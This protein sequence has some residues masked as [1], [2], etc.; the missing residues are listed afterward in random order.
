MSGEYSDAMKRTM[1]TRL[2]QGNKPA[3]IGHCVECG[4]N[5]DPS[6]GMMEPGP[7]CTGEIACAKAGVSFA[8]PPLDMGGVVD[9]DLLKPGG[10]AFYDD[11]TVGETIAKIRGDLVGMSAR[12][13]MYKAVWGSGELE[14]KEAVVDPDYVPDPEEQ[15]QYDALTKE[16]IDEYLGDNARVNAINE[17]EAAEGWRHNNKYALGQKKVPWHYIPMKVLEEVAW[18]MR[19]DDETGGGAAQYGYMNWRVN[20]VDAATYY[21][22]AMR[23]LTDWFHGANPQSELDAKSGRHHLAHMIACAL[24]VLDADAQGMLHDNRPART[25]SAQPEADKFR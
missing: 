6:T 20:G 16:G 3:K 18:I 19:G 10:L 2:P 14:V 17:R 22:A 21:D 12:A 7:V 9:V 8:R 25:A 13:K 5:F 23:H 4:G 15:A 11:G 1:A 24:I